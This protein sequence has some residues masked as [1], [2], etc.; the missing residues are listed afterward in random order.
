MSSADQHDPL[1][2]VVM[3]TFNEK[4][5]L[6]GKSIASILGQ[7]YRN[8]ELLIFDDSTNADTREKIDSFC[9]DERVRVF[10]SPERVGFVKSL[11]QGLRAAK[12]TYIARMDGDDM[13][14]PERIRKE[15]TFLES[16]PDISVVGGQINI[17]D[18]DDRIISRRKYPLGGIRLYL[19][20]C[21]RNPMA[22]PTVMMRR[23][24]IDQG[25]HYDESLKMS[26]DLDFWL[27]LLNDGYHIANLPDVILNY[28]V[29]R[30][31][32]AK[33]SSD[34]Q[35]KYMAYVRD[36]NF[37]GRHPFHSILSSACGWAFNH[38]PVGTINRMYRK[39]N[40][41]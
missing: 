21:A 28:R 9:Q 16:H 39:E 17:M 36:R 1:V 24:L 31:F 37:S 13:A 29:Q 33:R 26:E 12:G 10:R 4:P 18:E 15:V 11:N 23:T 7:T 38:V 20:S 22:H 2:S 14:L 25:Y 34:T 32:T 6:V 5:D 30:D 19:F 8:I 41:Q 35:R 27:R 40:K 3:A